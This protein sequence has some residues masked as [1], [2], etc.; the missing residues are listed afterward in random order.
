MNNSQINNVKRNWKDFIWTTHCLERIAERN[1]NLN[2]IF[3]MFE[4]AKERK[5]DLNQL[6]KDF[7]KNN[8]GI[9]LENKRYRFIVRGRVVV[10][11]I[12]KH[13]PRDRENATWAKNPITGKLEIVDLY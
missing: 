3:Q 13:S 6:K 5:K 2:T 11:I 4:T 9:Y 12:D 1:W 8:K 10:T 7:I